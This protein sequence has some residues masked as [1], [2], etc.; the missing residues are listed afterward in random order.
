M[1]TDHADIDVVK[2]VFA[3]F[4]ERDVDG[5]LALVSDEV[6]F[7]PVTADYAGRTG[8]YVGHDGLREYFRDVASVWDDIQVTPTDFR[9][10]GESVLVTGKVSASSPARLIAGSSGWIWRVR[11][12]K[13]VYGR[14]YPSASA[15]VEA[16]ENGG[17]G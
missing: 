10:A 7:T 2:A 17:A 13:V 11:D 3:A 5:M 14:V 6:V 1:A 8:P 9:Q 12:G 15:A 16:F 4:S